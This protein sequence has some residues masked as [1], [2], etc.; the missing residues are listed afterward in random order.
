MKKLYTLLF[1]LILASV[2]TQGIAQRN[3][4][5]WNKG[6]VKAISSSSVDSVTF[7]MDNAF[8]TITAADSAANITA[9]SFDVSGS[10]SLTDSL[11]KLIN[12]PIIGICYSSTNAEPL[13]SDDTLA[14]AT[15]FGAKKATLTG[16]SR[17]T[18]YYYRLYVRLLG[19]TFY[20]NVASATT[21]GKDA[22]DNSREI[23]GHR[24]I[25]LGLPSGLLWAETNLGAT[26]A[27]EY[28]SYFAWGE[29]E[30]KTKFTSGNYT[31]YN[32]EHT[33]NLTSVED[34]AT[35]MW[36][37]SVRIPTQA[38]MEELLANCTLTWAKVNGNAG[39]TFS[40]KTNGNEIFF[41]AAGM[42]VVSS[43]DNEG[44][45]GWYWTST[46]YETMNYAYAF[47]FYKSHT[48]VSK[49]VSYWG[50]RIRPVA[51]IKAETENE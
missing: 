13:V 4:Y 40:S 2:W 45:D 26:T 7:S 51:E 14:L 39:Y 29:T 19:E 16:L 15:G 46:P 48:E 22:V 47:S 43:T 18:T 31:F 6:A 25:D 36:G 38:E 24:F 21:L 33:G 1:S 35:A 5:V 41:P 12:S 20:G 23:N 10:V 17:G 37:D 30:A 42:C 28:G 11:T 27:G 32:Q 44:S 3:V 34:A 49:T 50:R 9:K 8:F